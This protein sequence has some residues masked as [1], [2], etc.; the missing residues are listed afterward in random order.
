MRRRKKQ[1]E[2]V[3]YDSDWYYDRIDKGEI[4]E[5]SEDWD[6]EDFKENLKTVSNNFNT[7]YLIGIASVGTWRGRFSG[8]VDD[9]GSDVYELVMKIIRKGYDGILIYL[10]EDGDLE[11]NLSHHDGTNT[12]IIRELKDKY[13]YDDY[14]DKIND[15]LYKGDSTYAYKYTKSVKYIFKGW[16]F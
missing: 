12:V 16:L 9:T 1:K 7:K 5:N 15:Y 11:L 4:D 8:Y 3:L 2:I 14:I 10:N 6:W 13:N